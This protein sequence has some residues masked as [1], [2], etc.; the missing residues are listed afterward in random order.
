MSIE[1]LELKYKKYYVDTYFFKGCLYITAKKSM[2][3]EDFL[4]L[5]KDIKK[6][7][8]VKKTH[9]KIES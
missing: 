6:L 8:N 1:D 2:L 7:I 9:L 3:V 5:K 4:E